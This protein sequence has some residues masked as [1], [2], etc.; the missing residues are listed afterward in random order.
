MTE[1]VLFVSTTN[2]VL[3]SLAAALLRFMSNGQFETAAASSEGGRSAAD[4]RT[5]LQSY[6]VTGEMPQMQ[7]LD[8]VRGQRWDYVTF[9]GGEQLS[10]FSAVGHSSTWSVPAG[11]M[12]T[13][14]RNLRDHIR[15]FLVQSNA[16][17]WPLGVEE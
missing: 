1:R 3:P 10:G 14:V 4:A 15:Q 9:L 17:V 16:G 13:G 5:F 11:D 12:T 2:A 8:D 7:S 6:G